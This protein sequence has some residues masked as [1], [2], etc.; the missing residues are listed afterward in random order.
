MKITHI[1]QPPHQQGFWDIFT[2]APHRMMF[3]AG[4][5]QLILPVIFWLHELIALY[6]GFWQPY[7]FITAASWLHGFIMLYAVFIFFIFGF[8][9]TTFPRWMNGPLIK[10][11]DYIATFTWCVIGISI[12]EFGILHQTSTAV[13]GLAIFLFGWALGIYY[14]YRV[15]RLANS[16]NKK[17]ES[18]LLALLSAGWLGAASFLAWLLTDNWTFLQLS[19]NAGLWIYLVPILFTVSLRML[20]FFSSN[21]IQHYSLVQPQWMPYGIVVLGILHM[22]LSIN[23]L[24]QWSFLVDLP[25]ALM[26]S[27]LSYKWRLRDSL[28]NSLLAILHLS[29]IWF[30]IGMY[31]FSIQSINYLISGSLMFGKAP[32]HAITIGFISAMMMA[33]VTRVT[34]GHS[35][36]KLHASNT[37]VALFLGVQVAAVIR[38]LADIPM[39]NDIINLNLSIVSAALWL[40]CF[41]IWIGIYAPLYLRAR[42]DG[43]PG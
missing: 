16:Q 21:V 40:L 29:F 35:G 37:T 25:M 31:L 26:G 30:S 4:S 43:Q 10:K 33:M 5:I 24:F 3:F 14:L 22:Q 41:G 23:Q 2:A 18:L 34:L 36:R 20:P 17:I 38:I 11:Q 15:L 32:I 28:Q 9:M 42:I 13:Y 19:L 7:E 1:N 39:L 12:F 27:Y 8:L 6:T